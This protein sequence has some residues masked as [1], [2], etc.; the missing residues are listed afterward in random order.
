MDKI[1]N[2]KSN[3]LIITKNPWEILQIIKIGTHSK[4]DKLARI[5]YFVLSSI[6]IL[7]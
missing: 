4:D 6:A 3:Q 2:Q 5:I 1:S 7:A